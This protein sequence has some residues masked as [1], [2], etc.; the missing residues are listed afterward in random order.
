MVPAAARRCQPGGQVRRVG[1]VAAGLAQGSAPSRVSRCFS[2]FIAGPGRCPP[3]SRYAKPTAMPIRRRMAASP[4]P[5]PC[6]RVGLTRFR[7]VVVT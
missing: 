1:E 2:V 6:D 5:S 3:G 4:G 7:E